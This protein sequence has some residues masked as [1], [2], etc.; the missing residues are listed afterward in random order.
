VA[1]NGPVLDVERREG[2]D[3]SWDEIQVSV[4]LSEAQD[5]GTLRVWSPNHLLDEQVFNASMDVLEWVTHVPSHLD[6]WVSF[7]GEQWAVS[8]VRLASRRA[9]PDLH[10]DVMRGADAVFNGDA[11]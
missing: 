4:Q 5:N 11:F 8:S 1:G 7:E 6:V 2:E 9:A 10:G 3:P